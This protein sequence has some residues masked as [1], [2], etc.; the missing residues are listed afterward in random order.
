MLLKGFSTVYQVKTTG[1]TK[2]MWIKNWDSQ[3]SVFSSCKKSADL[4]GQVMWGGV[5]LL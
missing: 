3:R 1:L 2:Y 5:F 4:I